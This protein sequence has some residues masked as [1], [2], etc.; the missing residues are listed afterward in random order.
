MSVIISNASPLISLC[1]IDRLQILEKLWKEIVIP[2][3]VYR[4]VVE[5][6]KTCLEKG[7][8]N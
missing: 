5:D 1:S 2:K 3:A 6:N 7:F 8:N 4:E